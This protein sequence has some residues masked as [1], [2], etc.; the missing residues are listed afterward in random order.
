MNTEQNQKLNTKTEKGFAHL[1]VIILVVLVVAVGGYVFLSN[2]GYV[3]SL[4]NLP[5]PGMNKGPKYT[6]QS[7]DVELKSA[8]VSI[9]DTGFTPATLTIKK[10]TTVT[11]TNTDQK[12]HRVAADPYPDKSSL[13]D[14]DSADPLQQND[15]YSY[16]FDTAGKYTYTDYLNPLKLH[17]TIVVE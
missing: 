11:W 6:P 10:G 13:P 16:T 15:A 3:P 9:S 7:A 14:L 12:P 8:D 1:I 4:P 5:I 17:G 2:K